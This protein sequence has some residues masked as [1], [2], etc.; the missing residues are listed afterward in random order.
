MSLLDLDRLRESGVYRF[1]SE[2]LERT[3]KTF[4][5]CP[6]DE[7]R[8]AWRLMNYCYRLKQLAERRI[9]TVNQALS[10]SNNDELAGECHELLEALL[11]SVGLHAKEKVLV[12]E[13]LALRLRGV[14]NPGNFVHAQKGGAGLQ[15]LE[16]H[17]SAQLTNYS[18]SGI[19]TEHLPESAVIR[20]NVAGEVEE[21]EFFWGDLNATPETLPVGSS[22]IGETR[23]FRSLSLR[24]EEEDAEFQGGREQILRD[25]RSEGID[26]KTMI[27]TET[28]AELLERSARVWAENL[29]GHS[30]S[31]SNEG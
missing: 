20:F 18:V 1:I 10:T 2:E 19:V 7:N 12:I 25:L 5:V 3:S 13:Q 30:P 26:P 17:G 16:I 24:S 29:K 28:D 23:L 6:T 8:D 22:V 21:R 11:E 31:R 14:A 9:G 27:C 4:E 15:I